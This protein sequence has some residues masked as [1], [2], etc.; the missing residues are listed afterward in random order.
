MFDLSQLFP[1]FSPAYL[2]ATA[3][4]FV[5]SGF[6]RTCL[7]FGCAALGLP[8]LLLIHDQPLF[9]IPVIGLQLLLFSGLT[10]RNR[11]HNVD[12][13]YLR[14]SGRLILPAAF[15]GVFGLLNLPNSVLLG[16]IYGITLFYALLWVLDRKIESRQRWVDQVLLVL[17]GY[18]AG[19]SLT[20]AP[21]MIAVF[22][23]H[24]ALSQLRDTLFVLW[25]IIVAFKLAT[26]ATLA[27]PLNFEVAAVLVPAAA[28]GHWAGLRTHDVLLQHDG[29]TK[30][31]IGLLLILVSLEGLWQLR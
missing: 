18:V 30:R 19:S 23:R 28:I 10:L 5:W 9:W 24:V 21:L 25:F 14:R 8:F 13:S 27:V 29:L 6:V 2:V 17:G 16:C 26:L 11:L 20:G 4:V 15:A 31:V 3:L 1:D 22:M 7:G 12:W